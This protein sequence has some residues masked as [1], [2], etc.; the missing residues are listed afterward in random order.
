MKNLNKIFVSVLAV[1]IFTPMVAFGATIKMGEEVFIQKG[2]DIDNNLYLAGG[3][4]SINTDVFGD[5]LIAGGNVLISDDVTDDV[6]AVGGS[7]TILGNVGDDTR[8]V[9][10]DILVAGSVNGDL[11]TIGGSIILSS[12][13]SVGKDLLALGGQISVDGDVLGDV[14]I[15]GGVV[16]INGHIKGDL[17]VKASEKLT[18][19]DGAIIDGKLEYSAKN[20]D[21]L[22]ISENAVVNGETIFKETPVVKIDNT[23]RF[24][25]AIIGTF[26]LFKLLTLIVAALLLTWLFKKFSSSVVENVVQK[27][28]EMLGKGFVALV[29]IPSASALLFFTLI[30]IPF[31]FILMLS[32]GLLILI[33]C[34]YAGVVAGAWISKKSRKSEHTII[35]WKNVLGGVTLLTVVKLVPIIGWTIGLLVFLV[36]IGSIADILHKKLF[37]ER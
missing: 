24:I 19:G 18:L 2:A 28:L 33:S 36:T 23:E 31:G 12:D 37:K 14:D 15:T 30:G 21:A 13:A 4:V 25:P 35:T 29:V 1:M 16:T 11:V 10:G 9:G 17:K 6:S 26:I 32:Y 5:I 8:V 27:P 3:N 22:I 34:V 20:A 7:V